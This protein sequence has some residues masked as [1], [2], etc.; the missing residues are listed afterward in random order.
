MTSTIIPFI[1]DS[2]QT[3]SHKLKNTRVQ[4]QE[5]GP[6][7]TPLKAHPRNHLHHIIGLEIQKSSQTM[8][9]FHDSSYS[10]SYP[11][12]AVTLAYFL[13]YPN[14]FSTHVLST[15]VLSRHY[16]PSTRT[17]YTTRL[18]L[19]RSRI[20]PAIM[21]LLPRSLLGP[22]PETANKDGNSQSY[23]LERSIVDM[24][25]GVM[26]TESRN[27]EFT[28]ILGVVERQLY[29]RPGA[30]MSA[31][32]RAYMPPREWRLKVVPDY[33]GVGGDAESHTDVNTKVELQSRLGQV[34]ERIQRARASRIGATRDGEEDDDEEE[35]PAKV[36]FF[37]AWSTNSIQKSIEAFGLRRAE[38]AV[39][40]SQS[41]MDVVLER[42]RGGGLVAVLEG[43][44]RDRL[45]MD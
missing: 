9:K 1:K 28:G 26:V 8:V 37:R 12:P 29:R 30:D 27:L 43:M 32:R 17:L 7:W 36:G 22:T 13:R 34:R 4:V 10:H 25:A 6:R 31:W 18:H 5:A 23:V 38:R 20:P 41:G 15:D 19:K 35:A 11:F 3:R 39:P 42:L 16:D 14:P 40:K 44:K 2:L 24:Q 33:G 45:L 21:K